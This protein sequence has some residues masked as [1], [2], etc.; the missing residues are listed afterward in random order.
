VAH[1]GLRTAVHVIKGPVM[2]LVVGKWDWLY[3]RAMRCNGSAGPK[4]QV[5]IAQAMSLV[6]V[7]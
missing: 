4:R 5:M 6:R 2:G 7:A 3:M 1:A